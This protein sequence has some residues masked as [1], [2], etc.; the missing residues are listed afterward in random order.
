MA[1]NTNNNQVQYRTR[2]NQFIRVPQVRVI[3]SDGSNGGIMNTA[4]ALK[5]AKDQ[6]LD[7]IEIN[8]KALPPVVRIADRGKMLYEEKKKIQEQKK[9]QQVQELKEITFRPAT[10]EG[11]LGHKLVKAKEFL[12]KGNRVKLTIR[13]RG[14]ELSHPNIGREK[15][16]YCFQQLDGMI[17]PNPQINMEGKF[18]SVVCSPIKNK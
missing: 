8:P 16:E 18:M 11:D 6:G 3:L 5:L 10:G 15:L 12:E 9:S 1:N 17:L 13:F 7:L 2:I 14:R 4:D